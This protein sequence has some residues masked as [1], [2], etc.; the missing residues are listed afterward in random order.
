MGRRHPIL[1]LAVTYILCKRMRQAR[2]VWSAG[3]QHAEWRG[4]FRFACT[5]TVHLLLR[6]EVQK[7]LNCM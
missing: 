5:M 3:V 1:E 7:A 6:V 2:S 4:I